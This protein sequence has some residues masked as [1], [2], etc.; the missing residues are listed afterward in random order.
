MD[1]ELDEVPKLI[2]N[3]EH[4]ANKADA[5]NPGTKILQE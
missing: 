3:T 2:E 1:M 5:G 4:S